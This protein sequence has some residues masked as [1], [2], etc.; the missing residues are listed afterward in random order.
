[1]SCKIHKY[2]KVGDIVKNEKIWGKHM[3]VVYALGGNE[4]LPEMYVIPKGKTWSP[5]VQCNW[6]LRDAKLMGA[7]KRPFIKLKKPILLKLV[8]IS[9]SSLSEGLRKTKQSVLSI[10]SNFFS[11]TLQFDN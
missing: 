10:S 4:Y 8:S 9:R 7:S 3:F 1:M 6:D 2:F 5:S 11:R